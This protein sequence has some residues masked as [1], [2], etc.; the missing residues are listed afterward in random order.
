M[1]K[2]AAIKQSNYTPDKVSEYLRNPDIVLV[3]EGEWVTWLNGF[4]DSQIGDFDL[5]FDSREH[6]EN[7]LA[8]GIDKTII[9]VVYKWDL[10][11][12]YISIA[13][14]PNVKIEFDSW[15]DMT[16]VDCKALITNLPNDELLNY[17]R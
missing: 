2:Y 17:M 6:F 4:F 12:V 3:D 15:Q 14:K 5:T 13:H 11:K 8:N 9:E 1:I 10:G 16:E 7:W